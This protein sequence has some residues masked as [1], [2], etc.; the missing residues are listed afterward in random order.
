MVHVRWLMASPR[1][2]PSMCKCVHTIDQRPVALLQS[3]LLGSGGLW[4][5][6]QSDL[7]R[8]LNRPLTKGLWR[9]AACG[10][11]QRAPTL[12]ARSCLSSAFQSIVGSKIVA[13]AHRAL[14]DLQCYISMKNHV[15]QLLDLNRTEFQKHGPPW[16]PT[17]PNHPPIPL[18]RH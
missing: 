8:S 13:H 5:F 16:H 1:L 10:A 9:F 6:L 2:L 17:I 15:A 4:R 14:C 18:H 3:D 11:S 7:Q 12:C